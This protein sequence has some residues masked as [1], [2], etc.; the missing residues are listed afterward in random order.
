MIPRRPWHQPHAPVC[1][2]AIIVGLS[3]ALGSCKPAIE[4]LILKKQGDPCVHNAEC[5]ATLQCRFPLADGCTAKGACLPLVASQSCNGIPCCTQTVYCGCDGS[6]VYADAPESEQGKDCPHPDL[7]ASA[8]QFAEASA[9]GTCPSQDGGTVG[10]PCGTNSDCAPD[11]SC[12]Y[13]IAAGCSGSPTCQVNGVPCFH[14]EP[15]CGCNGSI[16]NV[17]CATPS[18]FAPAPVTGPQPVNGTCSVTGG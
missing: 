11:E 12:V 1:L 4:T 9:A 17:S 16:V 3:V 7:F 13:P 15:Y 10:R 18:G 6:L 8:P 2:A 5:E 14:E